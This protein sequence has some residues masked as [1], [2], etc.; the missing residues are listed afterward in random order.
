MSNSTHAASRS[1]S[2]RASPLQTVPIPLEHGDSTLSS[3]YSVQAAEPVLPGHFPGLAIFPGVCQI[4]CV[5]LTALIALEHAAAEHAAGGRGALRL[6]SIEN[7]RFLAPVFPGD[8]VRTDI[9]VR[10]V[11]AE[12][13]ICTATTSVRGANAGV[14]RLRYRAEPEAGDGGAGQN[15]G[16]GA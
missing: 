14:F 12:E 13:W 9:S 8:D 11:G 2:Q 15:E 3:L 1:R 10:K 4:E 6:V 7:A 16:R 5:H